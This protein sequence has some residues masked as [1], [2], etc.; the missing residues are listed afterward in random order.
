ME[1]TP[2]ADDTNIIDR[3]LRLQRSHPEAAELLRLCTFL[4]PD[5]IPEE[6]IVV[7][8]THLSPDLQI[9]ASDPFELDAALEALLEFL[10]DKTPSLYKNDEYPPSRA[11]CAQR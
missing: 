6:I 7:G 4:H 8:A 11:G 1:T 9:I 5:A 2:D 3:V 10:S